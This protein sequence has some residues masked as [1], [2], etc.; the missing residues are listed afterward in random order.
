MKGLQMK[1]LVTS[2]AVLALAAGGCGGSAEH[3]D[4]RGASSAGSKAE[5]IP[6]T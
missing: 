4:R 5:V 6:L 3:A 1:V 2:L